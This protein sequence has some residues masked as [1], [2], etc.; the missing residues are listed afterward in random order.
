[1]VAEKCKAAACLA[2]ILLYRRKRRKQRTKRKIW[3]REWIQKREESGVVANLLQELRLGDETF[4]RNFLRMSVTDFDYLLNKVSPLITKQDTLM[5]RAITPTERLIVTLRYL[6]TG[7]SYKSLMYL[8]RIPA[9]T[10]STIIP[11]VCQ[12]IYNV[13]KDEYLKIPDTED[14][15]K[16]V[17]RHFAEKWNFPNCLGAIDGK[18]INIK[19]PPNSGSLY[20]N[21]KQAHSIILMGLANANYKFLYINIGAPGRDSDG[22]VYMNCSLSQAL[23]N[24]TLNIPESTPLPGR[25]QP[26]PY[27]VVADDAF[28]LKP[29]MLKP[30]AFKSQSVPERI[31]NYPLSSPKNN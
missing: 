2:V 22:G 1:M 15:W 10:I 14:E 31:F 30:F 27:V 17:S 25:K 29:Y 8:F 12:A 19:A 6:A 3:V 28:A 18:H 20:F 16:Q 7:D 13:L 11:E 24:N 9:N 5:R 21:Y 23:E 26:I 4:Y